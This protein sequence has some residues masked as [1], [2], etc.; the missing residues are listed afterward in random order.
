M[1]A[2]TNVLKNRYL[3]F[4]FAV[5]LFFSVCHYEGLIYDAVLYVTQY[6]YSINPARF[7]ND[8]AFAFGNQ[9]SL[10]FFSPILGIFL[11]L[12]GVAIGAF[13]Y[14]I[15]MQLAWIVVAVF[16]VKTLLRRIK[17]SIWTLPVSILLTFF[18]AYGIEFAHIR[19]FRYVEPYACSR[20]L[21]VV[22]GMAALIFLF[23]QKKI[24]SLLFILAGTVIHPITAGWCLPFWMFYFFPKTRIPILVVSFIFPFSYLL[25]VGPL[26]I[27]P[28][29][30]LS[31]PLAFKPD[32]TDVSKYVL[33]LTFFVM[34]ARCAISEE[35]KKISVSL[36]LL[37]VIS[38]YWDAW[39]GFGEHI[40]LYQV[41][42]WRLAWLPSLIAAPLGLCCVKDSLHKIAKK[43]NAT[44]HDL[45]VFLFVTS[46]FAPRNLILVSILALFLRIKK[47]KVVSLKGWSVIFAFFLLT[48]FLVQQYLTWCLQ[49]F[50]SFLG[51]NY[52]EFYRIRDAFLFYQFAFSAAFAVYFV[53]QR[54]FF[55]AIILVLSIFL[56]R[57]MLLPILALFL[58]F[59]PK[60]NKLRFWAGLFVIISLMFFDGL[61]DVD[62]RRKTLIEGMCRSFPWICIASTMSLASIF[63]TKKFSY[64]S[65]FFWVL[66]CSVVA[67]VSY[68]NYSVNW[69]EKESQIDQYLHETIFPQ[70]KERGKILFYV[71]GEFDE[72]PRLQFLTGSYLSRS[73]L[74]GAVFNKENYRTGLERSHLLYL[75]ERA[76]QVEKYYVY[77]AI[78]QKIS[79]PDT[80]IDRVGFLCELNEIS[81]L[82][83]DR[84]SL[85]FVKEDSAM[86]RTDQKVFLYGCSPSSR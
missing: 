48:S 4:L 39:G 27:L 77:S 83:T 84:A 76:P 9:D 8:P 11:E 60:E 79:E 61:I 18:F 69:L 20:S 44:T 17:Q 25:R 80:L 75:R 70:V 53:V 5:P 71:S 55:P 68:N 14:T 41:Q 6:V 46:F 58:A 62:A 21:S 10:G 52:M 59:C 54:K 19:F 15:V 72:E 22:L 78:L 65:I 37:I 28:A 1:I 35:V 51:F 74:V 38:L 56:S 66:I 85:P 86:V 16:F 82:V 73:T 50:P 7:A 42:P 2:I 30:W 47:V 26:D 3:P 81:H 33:L 13:A 57:F 24:L 12:F 23:N 36:A 29:D 32:Y 45:S 40:F 64:W 67:V 43:K 31:R 34:L 49:G 63:L